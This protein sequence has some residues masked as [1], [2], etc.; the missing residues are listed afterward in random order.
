MCVN[1][2]SIVHILNI[3]I[4]WAP[5]ILVL[6]ISEALRL[7]SLQKT[8][9]AQ[10][11]HKQLAPTKTS[12]NSQELVFDVVWVKTR[13]TQEELGNNPNNQQIVDEGISRTNLKNRGSCSNTFLFAPS[14]VAA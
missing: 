3:R 14:R 8:Q 11:T 6:P 13:R 2:L 1:I 12:T 5:Q 7:K 9:H 10:N 4:N